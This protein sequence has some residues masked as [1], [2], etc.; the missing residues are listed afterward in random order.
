MGEDNP[1]GWWSENELKMVF[2]RGLGQATFGK[3]WSTDLP[4]QT[5]PALTAADPIALPSSQLQ[6]PIPLDAQGDMRTDL[7]GFPFGDDKHQNLKVWQNS[8]QESNKTEIFRL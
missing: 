4:S 7:L 3:R 5:Y 8:W 2:L 1:G 6:Q